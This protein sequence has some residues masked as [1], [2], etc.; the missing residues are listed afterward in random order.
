VFHAPSAKL[1]RSQHGNY[2]PIAV[3]TDIFKPADRESAREAVELPR[4]RFIIGIFSPNWSYPSLHT[5][6]SCLEAFAELHR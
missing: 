4:D 3:D 1:R 2:V 5:L 6:P